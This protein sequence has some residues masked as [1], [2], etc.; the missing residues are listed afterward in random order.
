IDSGI[1]P[2]KV[3]IVNNGISLDCFSSIHHNNIRKDLGISDTSTVIGT[4]GRLSSEKGHRVL[5]HIAKKIL[6]THPEAVFLVV[7][8]G[9]LKPMLEKEFSSPSI[10]FT[11][12]RKDL[13]ELYSQMDIF[14]LPSLTEGLPM[15]ILE[16]M[17][18]KT[19][20]ISTRVGAIPTV[21]KD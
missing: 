14:V 16:A 15:V 2:T 5:L 12:S 17:A 21:L 10:I 7:G 8:D 13:A 1:S 20:I 19:P 18:S 9:P 6:E 3:H 11:G 4:V